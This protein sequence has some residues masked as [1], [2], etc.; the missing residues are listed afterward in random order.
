MKTNTDILTAIDCCTRMLKKNESACCSNCPYKKK[1]NC[2]TLLLQDVKR[3]I[4]IGEALDFIGYLKDH[5]DG[6]I[7]NEDGTSPVMQVID[8]ATLDKKYKEFSK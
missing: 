1:S 7:F 3:I 5:N 4:E 8:V 6:T 2:Y